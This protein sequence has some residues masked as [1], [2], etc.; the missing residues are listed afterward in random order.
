MQGQIQGQVAIS[1]GNSQSQTNEGNTQTVNID[2]PDKLI[3]NSH[4][5]P[6][7]GQATDTVEYHGPVYED[8][9]FQK[10]ILDFMLQT[11]DLR[12]FVVK[13]PGLFTRDSANSDSKDLSVKDHEEKMVVYVFRSMED[14]ENHVKSYE[15]VGC[16]DTFSDGDESLLDCFDQAVID[17]GIMGGN[18]LVTLKVDYMA[19]LESTT[20]GLGGSGAGGFLQGAT[21]SSV[22]GAALGYAKSRAIPET[23]PYIHG[24]V[25]YSEEL[26]RK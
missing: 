20:V 4:L 10:S 8:H 18:I 6:M 23:D 21:Q 16:T 17:A 9:K 1:E 12:P 26:V 19:A 13:K 5:A 11:D 24:I 7:S 25:L 15:L 3:V 14:L 22:Y 2:N